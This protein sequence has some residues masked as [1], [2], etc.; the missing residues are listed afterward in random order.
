MPSLRHRVLIGT[1]PDVVYRA[2]TEA[3]GLR[4]WWTPDA[5]ATPLEGTEATFAFGDRYFD[6]MRVE[7]LVPGR[8]V[9]WTCVEGD[10]EWVDTLLVFMLDPEKGGRATRVRFR[11]VG[12]RALTPFMELCNTH[13]GRYLH[14]LRRYCETG[15]GDP[16]PN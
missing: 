5:D 11:H 10:P 13:W 15:V 1:P 4:A 3:G 12:W 16:Y 6:R 8:E 2:L 14:S 7:R 9:I